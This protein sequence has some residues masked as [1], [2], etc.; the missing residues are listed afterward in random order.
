MFILDL[1]VRD[2]WLIKLFLGRISRLKVCLNLRVIGLQRLSLRWND[3][4]NS[5]GTDLC[6]EI[7]A[8]A[9]QLLLKI[10]LLAALLTLLADT[11]LISTL[12]PIG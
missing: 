3:W 8:R 12:L 9:I 4:V 11:A 6:L 10:V 2:I 5:L 1:Q 7:T